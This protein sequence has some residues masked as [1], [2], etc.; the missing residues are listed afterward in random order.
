[1]PFGTLMVLAVLWFGVSLPLV[2]FGAFLGYKKDAL[3]VPV[4]TNP[5]P[6]QIPPQVVFLAN[7]IS[8]LFYHTLQALTMPF[9]VTVG[10]GLL[11]EILSLPSSLLQL[12]Y[13]QLPVSV[14]MGGLLSFGAVFV[15]MFFIISSIWQV[16]VRWDCI[17]AFL[18]LSVSISVYNSCLPLLCVSFESAWTCFPCYVCVCVCVC[19][20]GC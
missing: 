7:V 4:Q 9:C 10:F 20:F 15:E 5:I 3:T 13:L 12:W 19:V 17:V 1:V 18:A 16:C 14:L 2:F 6:R 8:G 11:F